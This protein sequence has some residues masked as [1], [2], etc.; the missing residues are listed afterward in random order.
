MVRR[1][2]LI[3]I[4]SVLSLTA[5]NQTHDLE[6]YLNEGVKNS[7]LL[8]EYKNQIRSAVTDS[9]IV[10]AAK[11]PALDLNSQLL[12]SP[13]YNNFGYDE[14]VTD[15]GNYSAV[16]G[17]KQYILNKKEIENKYTSV[18]IQKQLL[19]NSSSI[20]TNALNK[21]I[22]D[23]YLKAF[24][25]FTQLTFSRDFLKLVSRENDIV[26]QFV[27]SGVY[28][29]TDYL[30]LT[31][32]MQTQQVTV[33]QLKNQ[34]INDLFFLNQ[35]CGITDTAMYEL[36]RPEIT[37]HGLPDI[38]GSPSWH[39]F[40]ID[41]AR[42][43]TEKTAVDIKYKPKVNWFA[44]AGF[45]TSNPW[46]FYR[47]FG[48]SAGIGLNIPVYDGK[49]QDLQ[50][51]KLELEQNSLKNYQYTYRNQF[52]SRIQQLNSELKMLD[53]ISEG[54]NNQ[55]KTTG[56]LLVAL[57]EQLETGLIQ[58]TDYVNAIK[59]YR[60]INSNMNLLNIQ[61]LQIISELNFLSKQ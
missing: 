16:L 31:V 34:Y 23:Q 9:L 29:I 6:Y 1:F 56:Q 50:K 46:D 36:N 3:F 42:I 28:K 45:L 44:D 52:Y 43:E 40:R 22:T 15:G 51:Q 13:A 19:S 33:T 11:K 26:K 55:L 53:E 47:H 58:M 32:E 8:N 54:M 57:K 39:K 14:V 59:N 17:V 18:D 30:N 12:Y 2:S 61:K 5:F 38:N 20:S 10:R 27:K 48:Y 37:N 7:P 41:S 60:T 49:Q 35:I 21:I 25:S 24:L 4:F